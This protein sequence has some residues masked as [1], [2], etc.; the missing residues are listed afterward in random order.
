MLVS[1]SVDYTRSLRVSD[2]DEK[3]VSIPIDL[4][5]II[6]SQLPCFQLRTTLNG[7]DFKFVSH[8][9]WSEKQ[10][11]IRQHIHRNIIRQHIHVE[12]N[13]NTKT[14][15]RGHGTLFDLTFRDNCGIKL[16]LGHQ[17][18]SHYLYL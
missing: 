1:E 12:I 11:I 5:G 10:N 17:C 9:L 8:G 2:N 15:L 18:G 6:T 3:H 16:L 7:I 14:R 4:S 13:L